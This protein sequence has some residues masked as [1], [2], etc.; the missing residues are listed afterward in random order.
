LVESQHGRS[1]LLREAARIRL[2]RYR[3]SPL[4]EA[5]GEDSLHAI[6]DWYHVAILE[7]LRLSA[8]QENPQW[9]AAR[10]GITEDEAD[11]ALQR[12]TRLGLIQSGQATRLEFAENPQNFIGPVQTESFQKYCRQ[13]LSKAIEAVDDPRLHAMHSYMIAV[14][15]HNLPQLMTLLRETM[16]TIAARMEV[17]I[18]SKNIVYC[19]TGQ[20]FPVSDQLEE[21]TQRSV[22]H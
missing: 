9:I 19:L 6:T 15:E 10:L 14:A 4:I 21:K 2:R 18:G 12:L 16:D 22:L 5:I 11:T 8:A 1:R 3:R 20:F 13:I 17:E 7:L